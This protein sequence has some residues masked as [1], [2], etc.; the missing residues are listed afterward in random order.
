[1]RSSPHS[2]L[3]SILFL[4]AAFALPASAQ[5]V[6]EGTLAF[7]GGGTLLEG[8]RAAFQKALRQKK[9]GFAGIE[10]LTIGRLSDDYVVRFEARA[11]P[12]NGDYRFAFQWEKTDAFYLKANFQKFRIFYDGSG[13]RLLPR[14]LAVSWF[15]DD[16]A[17]DRSYFYVELGNISRLGLRWRLRYDRNT[18]SGSK[19]SLRWGDS[20]LGAPDFSPRAFIP[21][22]TLLDETRDI[23]T[24]EASHRTESTNWKMAG[25]YER[26]KVNNTDVSRRRALEPQ[27]RYLTVNEG[28]ASDLFSGHAFYERFISEDLRISAGGLATTIDTNL[29]GNRIYGTTP[30]AKFLPVFTGGQ[31]GDGGYTDLNGNSQLKQ[32]I[33]N[34]NLYYQVTKHLSV[35]PA[36]KFEHL[37]QE[38]YETHTLTSLTGTA[39]PASQLPYAGNNQDSWD[40][41]TEDLEVRYQ[42]WPNLHLSARGQWNQ[43]T[44]NLAEQSI[45]LTNATTAIDHNVDY[46]RYGQ[47]YVT[48]ATWYARPGLTFGAQ[49]NYRLKLADYRAVRDST[50]NANL[51]TNRDRYPQFIVDNDIAS[52]DT[53][54]R[55]SWRRSANLNFTTRYAFQKSTV[56]TS[57][58]NLGEIENGR[59]TRHVVTQSATW[60]PMPQLF[61]TGTVN[62]TFD[63]LWVPPHRLTV[64]GDNNYASASLSAGYALGKVTDVFI[65][66]YHYRADNYTSNPEVTLPLN[67]GLTLNTAFLTW[68]RRHSERLIYTVKYGYATNRDGTYGGQNDFTAHVAYAKVQLK[69]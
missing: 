28:A 35:L 48:S 54:L 20:N 26:T 30:N 45:L 14:D 50:S 13:G 17:V 15:S 52:H 3:P 62:V 10:D 43:G 18:R 40:E 6:T 42:R 53:T 41:V 25:R 31:S 24:L 21:S 5:I 23:V 56:T 37:G 4:A 2:T 64:T 38:S 51:A 69:F 8:D 16:L 47:R 36:V 49:Y 46:Q 33:G 19:N 61:V 55:L 34:A 11:L 12:G 1:M 39:V 57:F 67:S 32:Y 65:D 68:V 29:S 22:Y 60:T 27:D 9:D 59:L 58:D 44:G 66:V 7:G 63:Q